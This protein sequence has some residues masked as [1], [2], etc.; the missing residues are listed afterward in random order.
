MTALRLLRGGGVVEPD[1]R[2]AVYLLLQDG[3]IAPDET[4]GTPKGRSRNQG[5]GGG[6]RRENEKNWGTK[7]PGR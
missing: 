1:Q 2:P 4:P 6:G 7:R 3:K 5:G